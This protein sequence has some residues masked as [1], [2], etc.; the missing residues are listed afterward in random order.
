M[1]DGVRLFVLAIL[2]TALAKRPTT[3]VDSAAKENAWQMAVQKPKATHLMAASGGGGGSAGPVI[4][5][6]DSC[7]VHLNSTLISLLFLID[8]CCYTALA[9]GCISKLHV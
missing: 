8:G 6:D 2:N 5:P 1:Y 4:A 3:A 7:Q 9:Y